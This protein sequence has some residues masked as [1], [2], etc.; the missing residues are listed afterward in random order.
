M[1]ATVVRLTQRQWASIPDPE[2][3]RIQTWRWVTSEQLR[4][5]IELLDPRFAEIIRLSYEEG[6]PWA[7][8][9]RRLGIRVGTVG[10]LTFRGRKRLRLIL[11]EQ[12]PPAFR[13]ATPTRRW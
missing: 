8:I 4:E 11:R 10:A 6:L 9:A 1:G 5:A 2:P 3:E 7:E 12:L 13:D